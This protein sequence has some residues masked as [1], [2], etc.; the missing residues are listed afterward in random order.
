MKLKKI[1]LLRLNCI[2]TIFTLATA[3][4]IAVDQAHADILQVTITGGVN[5][6]GNP[7]PNVSFQISSQPTPL[8]SSTGPGFEVPITVIENS[9]TT[10]PTQGG[11]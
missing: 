11:E 5:G 7:D 2:L 6:N 9:I 3:A 1:K 8:P 10:T 4:M